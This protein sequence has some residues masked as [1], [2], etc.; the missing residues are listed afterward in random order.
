MNQ[1]PAN[2][3]A[4]RAVLG[5]VIQRPTLGGAVLHAG[6]K[7]EHFA[8]SSHGVI[9]ETIVRML[10][11]AQSVDLVTVIE[12]LGDNIDQLGGSAYVS[13]LTNSSNGYVLVESHV[14]RYVEIVIEKAYLRGLLRIAED[15]TT[16]ALSHNA[17]PLHIVSY[18]QAKL[19]S[20]IEVT[21]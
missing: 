3:D 9:F 4:E 6:L 12:E 18:A 20:L 14:L 1:S 5:S 2:L 8:C 16:S 13:D 10:D 19:A 21:G 7:A 15:I 11:E 17:N